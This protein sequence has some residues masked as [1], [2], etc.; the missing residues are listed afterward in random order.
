MENT[1]DTKTKKPVIPPAPKIK[2]KKDPEIEIPKFLL[3]E[4]KL[5]YDD[6]VK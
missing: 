2:P 5:Y 6:S 1:K 3:D 4:N